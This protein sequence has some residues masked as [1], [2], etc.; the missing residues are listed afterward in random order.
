MNPETF[1]SIHGL[2]SE[3][4]AVQ[5][6]AYLCQLAGGRI[7]FG[8]LLKELYWADR[9]SLLRVGQPVTFDRMTVMRCGPLL[10]Q[11]YD[12]VKAVFGR[13]Y[14]PS[15]PEL[16]KGVFTP[17]GIYYLH[18]QNDPG[19][20]ELSEMDMAFLR[21]AHRRCSVHRTFKHLVD[22]LHVTS[23]EWEDPG[24]TSMPLSYDELLRKR[25]WDQ[26]SINE[27]LEHLEYQ[28][29]LQKISAI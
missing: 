3:K 1:R 14:V 17:Q 27:C 28:A 12:R 25:G 20:G 13:P 21:K 5:A 9:A 6:A 23:P 8:Y 16:W 2:Y 15:L 26:E 4:K 22:W 10:S 19:V 29:S 18:L 24:D 11:V 7:D